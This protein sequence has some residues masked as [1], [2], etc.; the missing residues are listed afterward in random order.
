MNF[1][2]YTVEAF[3]PYEYVK[4]TSLAEA[5]E[6]VREFRQ[7]GKNSQIV[8]LTEDGKDYLIG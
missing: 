2:E 1:V 6:K 5:R 8:G 4:C 7:K 3:F